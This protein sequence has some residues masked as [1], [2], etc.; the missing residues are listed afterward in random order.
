MRILAAD[1]LDLVRDHLGVDIPMELAR[2]VM[3]RA[4]ATPPSEQRWD[5]P[6]PIDLSIDETQRLRDRPD[7][8]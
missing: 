7:R 1:I 2:E 4:D 3:A 5:A 6:W 8:V